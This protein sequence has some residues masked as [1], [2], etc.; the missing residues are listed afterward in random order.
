MFID[1]SLEMAD[2]V[3]VF[4]GTSVDQFGTGKEI[5]AVIGDN[6]TVDLSGGE[7][8]YVVIEVTEALG[9]ATSYEIQFFTHT[10]ATS[11]ESGDLLFTTGAVAA[12]DFVVGKR[13]VFTLPEAEYKAFVG[14]GGKRVGSAV[15]AGKV[16][17]Y[18]TKDVRNWDGSK[19]RVPATDP[20][21]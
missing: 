7:P 17:A 14:I 15:S 16:N 6:A 10:A 9:G 20:A 1:S 18:I 3:A 8:I 12:A 19:T 5:R 2:N 13:F 11:I 21:N 4:D